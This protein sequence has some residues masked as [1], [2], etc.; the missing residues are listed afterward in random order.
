MSW[1]ELRTRFRQGIGKHTD[2]VLYRA[3]RQPAADQL[4]GRD[5]LPGK[6]FF[7]PAEL[8][9]RVRLFKQHLPHE[10]EACVREANEICRHRFRLLGYNNLDYGKAQEIDW[11][12]DVVHGKRT[13][14]I[15]WYKIKFLD[16]NVAG[17]HKITWELNRHQYLVTLAKAWLLTGDDRY[18]HEAIT[19]W[20]S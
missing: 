3:G 13:P 10:A 17:D 7:S 14:L 19:Q 6:F 4:H 9:E 12:L 8:P 11:H 18:S 5:T 15:P 1:D 16:F 20:Y 2:A